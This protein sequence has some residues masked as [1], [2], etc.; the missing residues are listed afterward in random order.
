M[1]A[2]STYPRSKL[3]QKSPV[4][5]AEQT[6]QAV[7]EFEQMAAED[8]AIQKG[9]QKQPSMDE[10]FDDVLSSTTFEEIEAKGYPRI[11]NVAL[12]PALLEEARNNVETQAQLYEEFVKTYEVPKIEE[13]KLAVGFSGPSYETVRLPA[14]F[15]KYPEHV[16]NKLTRVIE[17]DQSVA[18]LLEKSEL[19][20]QGKELILRNFVS[21]SLTEEVVR[22]WRDIPSDITQTLPTLGGMALDATT[23]VWDSAWQKWS[24]EDDEGL[25]FSEYFSRY[26]SYEQGQTY[27]ALKKWSYDPSNKSV[28]FRSADQRLSAWY[29]NA[30]IEE[31]GED[32]WKAAHQEPATQVTLDEN[33]EPTGV[34]YVRDEDGNLVYED[35]VDPQIFGELVTNS[36]DT[37]TSGE[38]ALA[39]FL[40]DA[41]LVQFGVGR[42]VMKGNKFFQN[43]QNARK[44]NPEK[45]GSDM[46]DWQVH[47]SLLGE[48]YGKAWGR[49]V[50]LFNKTLYGKGSLERGRVL[51][52]HLSNLKDM[53]DKIT[54]VENKIETL[55]NQK[56]SI[57]MKR[58]KPDASIDAEIK[59]LESQL[60]FLENGRAA[61]INKSGGGRFVNPYS[62]AALVD[63]VFISGALGYAPEYTGPIFEAMG[64]S[65]ETGDVVTMLAA[66]FLAPATGR[67][68][69]KSVG[70]VSKKFP[71]LKEGT[72]GITDLAG[73]LENSSWLPFVDAGMLVRGDMAEIRNAAAAAGIELSQDSIDSITT[74]SKVLRSAETEVDIGGGKKVNMRQRIFDSLVNYSDITGRMRNRM[75]KMTDGE[76]NRIFT[77]EEVRENM[78]NLHLSLAHA[79][80][81]APLVAIQQLRINRLKPG[82]LTSASDMDSIFKALIQEESVLDGMDTAIRVL[83][84]SLATKGVKLD[85]NDPIQGTID[86]LGKVSKE[87]RD[88]LNV[89]KQE[90][91]NV[92]TVFINNPAGV[93]A[94]QLGKLVDMKIMAMPQDVRQVVDRAKVAEE[95]AGQILDASEQR[96]LA[97]QRLSDDVSLVDTRMLVEESAQTLF[98]VTMALRKERG[99]ARYKNVDE[100]AT[101]N[102]ITIDMGS[103]V[104]KM[105]D[106]D[107][108]LKGND[109]TYFFKGGK[110]FLAVEGSLLKNTFNSMARRGLNERYG[111]DG[112]SEIIAKAF[113]NG[114][115]ERPTATDFALWA[116]ENAED[117]DVFKY[118]KATVEEAE[119]VRRFFRDRRIASEGQKGVDAKGRAAIDQIFMDE[120]DN[121]FNIADESGKLTQMVEVA[122]AGWK[123][124]VGDVTETGTYGGT[125]TK[126]QKR[127]ETIVDEQTGEIKQGKRIYVS[128]N[129]RPEKPFLEIA[130]DFRKIITQSD[131][132]LSQDSINSMRQS[133]QRLMQFYGA[134]R[135]NG[136]YV[137]NMSDSRQRKAAQM[138]GGILETLLN[139]EASVQLQ[140]IYGRFAPEL[141]EARIPEEARQR[142]AAT[143]SE[144]VARGDAPSFDFARGNRML[145]VESVLRVPVMKDADSPIEYRTSHTT[146]LKQEFADTDQMLADVE[147]WKSGYES[148]RSDANNLE[149]PLRLA[150][151]RTLEEE[152]EAVKKL[153][154]ARAN[155]NDPVQ[156]FNSNFATATPDSIQKLRNDLVRQ[157]LSEAEVDISLK[158]MYMR[159]LMEQTGHK[160]VKGAGANDARQEIQDVTVL[161][162]YVS[163]PTKRAVMDAILGEE[164]AQFMQD[165]ADW[166]TFAIG[167]GAGFR[168]MPDTKGMSIDSAIARFFNLSRGL[169]S[170]QY[171]A[172]EVGL[173]IMLKRRQE[174]IQFALADRDAA[175]IIG[176]IL[177]TPGAIKPED[178]SLLGARIR[179]YI[180]YGEGG[181]LRSEGEI[182]AL[183]IFLG[184]TATETITEKQAAEL[185]KEAERLRQ[186]AEQQ[187]E[188]EQQENP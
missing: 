66:P 186:A 145:Q 32:G 135:V 43:V 45:Y 78:G 31:Y 68:G 99:S 74:F 40:S 36:F 17:T 80:G 47:T 178:I 179:S 109:I 93:D 111:E 22:T 35:K 136:E 164:H 26:Y 18:Q 188:D 152:E 165:I 88:K 131:E 134:D 95:V 158:A 160:Y 102:N 70:Y 157:G 181:L 54:T 98:D 185:E 8:I 130:S 159:G 175:G 48:K 41:P 15:D 146:Q 150:A 65:E 76:D 97:A 170:P 73:S 10:T 128:P 110:K 63:D 56:R 69:L 118:F 52:T 132:A 122:R 50:K 29:K 112:A 62:R 5:V 176:K 133:M 124:D 16:R 61:Y 55:Q 27:G 83:T 11:G 107:D 183:D 3:P 103:L 34:E 149:S 7:S 121:L 77:D 184:A 127:T 180:L 25:S 101:E 4:I 84:Q 24:E 79:S 58:Q 72:A 140:K 167:D 114:Q 153:E 85:S 123:Q 177:Q 166:S 9:E 6:A 171:V 174:L 51:N 23:S 187:D 155:A 105:L 154:L 125:V 13:Q 151:K 138:F 37:L 82:S 116:A 143:A 113:E 119:D 106:M 137:F 39:F 126:G 173:R 129:A 49:A 169:V 90:L 104:N 1:D 60:T 46:S 162:D 14:Y 71:I 115:I 89:K 172:T 12:D 144:R 20:M 19:P 67:L 100:Y 21:G 94:D 33:N 156:F 87:G 81:L 139:K 141:P 38:K 44:Q 91:D 182:P 59:D 163:D 108:E 57:L 96:L 28:I 161:T 2:A 75:L 30:F 142:V 92:I 148:I 86:M 147:E 120:V 168:A 64:F 42:N 117:G 53:Q